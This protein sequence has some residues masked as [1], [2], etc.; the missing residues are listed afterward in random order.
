MA[1]PRFGNLSDPSGNC[2]AVNLASDTTGITTRGI[3]VGGTG[4]VKIDDASG[5]NGVVF[6]S[7]PTG[8]VLPV[9]ATKIYATSNGTS[10][11]NLVALL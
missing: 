8:T 6:K 9:M 10:A 1:T 11:T 3:Y 4:D 2:Q 5:N 7:V